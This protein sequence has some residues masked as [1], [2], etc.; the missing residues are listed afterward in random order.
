[1]TGDV[2]QMREL[3]AKLPWPVEFLIVVAGAFGLAI[4]GS[5]ATVF[6]PH[7]AGPIHSAASLWVMVGEETGLLVV[8]GGFLYLRGWKGARL[9]LD[10]HW[11]DGVHGTA[12]T[13]GAYLA[14]FAALLLL[15][16]FFPKLAQDAAS[17]QVVPKA[18]SP[19]LI[20][21]VVI[22]NSVYEEV[23]VS[24][25]IITLLKEKISEDVAINVSVA[26][27]LSYHLYQGVLGVVS[28]IP[29]GLIF[30]YWFA[31]TGK[32]WPLIVAH[33]AIDLIGFLAR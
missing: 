19:L 5:I 31:K 32:L 1:M 20:G 21:A 7:A 11:M 12:L 13:A 27:R 9:G 22:V 30:A 33:A 10:S 24:G 17:V 4:A 26:V 14:Y 6:Q 16:R 2:L 29:V 28:I 23:F 15:A 25:Y 3:L 18:L 8:L